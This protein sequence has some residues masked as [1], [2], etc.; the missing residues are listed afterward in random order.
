MCHYLLRPLR[1]Q[2]T[3]TKD[4]PRTAGQKDMGCSVCSPDIVHIWYGTLAP[5]SLQHTTALHFIWLYVNRK[6]LHTTP[7]VF[8]TTAPR[9]WFICMCLRL[10]TGG[11]RGKGRW[12]TVFVC[13]YAWVKRGGYKHTHFLRFIDLGHLTKTMFL[14][15]QY[16]LWTHVRACLDMQI[17]VECTTLISLTSSWPLAVNNGVNVYLKVWFVVLISFK[18]NFMFC[19]I[20]A[21]RWRSG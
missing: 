21:A 4:N 19:V 14:H 12:Q 2:Y 18:G 10:Q 11:D 1:A 20:G 16:I 8:V 13:V 5:N 7:F 3:H 17:S 6:I 9:S 15:I